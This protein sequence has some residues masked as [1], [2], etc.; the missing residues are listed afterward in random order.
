[1]TSF[2]QMLK[3]FLAG[4]IFHTAIWMIY[5]GARSLLFEIFF[6]PLAIAMTLWVGLT[7]EGVLGVSFGASFFLVRLIGGL[8]YY[9]YLL[10]DYHYLLYD[11]ASWSSSAIDATILAVYGYVPARYYLSGKNR[12]VLFSGFF[13][14]VFV[15][16]I[17]R[18]PYMLAFAMIPLVFRVVIGGFSVWL[19]Y[20]HLNPSVKLP[21]AAPLQTGLSLSMKKTVRCSKCGFEN[22]PTSNY[23]GHCGTPIKE[24]TVYY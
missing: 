15:D 13:I 19:C 9:G 4:L 17:A 14:A 10:Y 16:M 20:R 5:L 1:M 23:C 24:E 22:S 7:R 3:Y 11:V 2:R 18:L 12:R 6:F 21:T 8:W